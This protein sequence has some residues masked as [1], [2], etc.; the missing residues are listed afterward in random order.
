MDINAKADS[1]P[2]QRPLVRRVISWLRSLAFLCLVDMALGLVGGLTADFNWAPVHGLVGGLDV[3]ARAWSNAL[4]LIVLPLVVSQL[5][6]AVAAGR[7]SKADAGRI[8]VCTPLV[9]LGLLS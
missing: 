3:L 8:G 9:F 2:R 1:A 5:F 7:T 6:L 4:Q